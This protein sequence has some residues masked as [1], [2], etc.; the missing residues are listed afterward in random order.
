MGTA[1]QSTRVTTVMSKEEVAAVLGQVGGVHGLVLRLIYASG[2]RLLEC[3]RL[4]VK[5]VDFA[6]RR[7]VIRD[8]DFCS[9]QIREEGRFFPPDCK[10]QVCAAH[11]IRACKASSNGGCPSHN[12]NDMR[13]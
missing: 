1:K 4:R 8:A 13:L 5:D 7:I 6:N 2:M 10:A 12:Q 9:Q 11:R 3:V